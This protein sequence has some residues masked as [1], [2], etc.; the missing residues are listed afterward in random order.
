MWWLLVGGMVVLGG[1]C[2]LDSRAEQ[3]DNQVEKRGDTLATNVVS[4]IEE[5]REAEQPGT[6][7]DQRGDTVTVRG[8]ISAGQ[9]VLSDSAFVF[10]QDK[11]AGI[12]VRLPGGSVGER[13]DLV[14]VR[15]VV[16]HRAG[17]TYLEGQ[18]VVEGKF[19][20]WN[21]DPMP[22]T[23]ATAATGLHA[24]QLVRVRGEVAARGQTKTG[25]Y[26]FLTDEE[27]PTGPQV[28]VF[29]PQARTEIPLRQF[30]VGTEVGVTGVLSRQQN[31]SAYPADG[32]EVTYQVLPRKEEEVQE[33]PTVSSGTQ[34][35]ILFV[36]GGTLFAVIAVMT[37]RS[38][39][40]RRTQQLVESR[41]RFRRLAEAT[42]EGIILHESGEILNVNRALTDM[43]GYS[44]QELV[45]H[46]FGDVLAA[47]VPELERED[48]RDHSDEIYETIVVRKNGSRF[49]V[50]VD[51]R[52]V[53]AGE[54]RVRVM[55]IRDITE[56]KRRETEL[57]R[58]KE[59]AEQMAR[60][61][62]SLLNN[63]SHEFRTPITSIL[64][65][66]DLILEEPDANHREF[67][68]R[69]RKSGERLSR[70]LQAVLEMA[71]IESGRVTLQ[72]E[73]VDLG[74]LAREVVDEY[75]LEQ[76]PTCEVNGQVES[77]RTD[78]RL[79][80]RVIEHLVHNAIK[81]TPET[82]RVSV[83]VEKREAA[84]HIAISDSGV[85]IDPAFQDDLFSP[86]EQES[87]GR[88]RTHE[89]MGLGLSL[90]K[91][92]LDLLDGTIDVESEKGKGSTFTVA[93]PVS[94]SAVS[95]T[96]EQYTR[97]DED[98]GRVG[99]NLQRG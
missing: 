53:A 28:A 65:Y 50:E 67:A 77:I 41:A 20:R 10:V 78:R 76:G 90:T 52:V 39:V 33:Q 11:T 84:V 26:L 95:S 21:P 75:Q 69:I 63:M 56:R 9:G 44:R 48:L 31:E 83:T 71:Q 19:V 79:I 99:G 96:V 97:L 82:G 13:G 27:T 88:T 49:P 61:K 6:V 36:V 72:N 30:N 89:G 62:S 86:F 43:T 22:I 45:G 47:S 68:Q 15:G 55:A 70:T 34:T 87:T 38:A 4:T 24:G 66:S 35:I 94:P 5:V 12:A 64:G 3:T 81:F 57:R 91:R 93:L 73:S 17:W 23:V 59:E 16:R 58:A 42:R 29:T 80:R 60:L 1:G 14:W 32:Q 54:K 74:T 98:G 18:R 25:S 2:I 37:L 40:R 8:R 51:Q 46:S 85:G 92:M 7:P